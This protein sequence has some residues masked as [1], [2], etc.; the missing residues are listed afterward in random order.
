M[1]NKV[2]GRTVFLTV[3]L[4]LLVTPFT[5]ALAIPPESWYWEGSGTDP[6]LVDCG[7]FF[8]DGE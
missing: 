1:K 7:S 3:L 5:T 6:G 2:L 4:T 8:I